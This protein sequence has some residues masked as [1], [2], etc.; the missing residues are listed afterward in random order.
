MGRLSEGFVVFLVL[1]VLSVGFGRGIYLEQARP[2]WKA[3]HANEDWLQRQSR[4]KEAH[5]TRW[6]DLM[7]EIAE[8]TCPECGSAVARE[9]GC[10]VC[11]VCG[12]SA[13]GG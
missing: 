3:L 10:K 9:E 6:G 5:R 8:R 2:I 7:A 4:A 1:A 13:C 11:K 12:W